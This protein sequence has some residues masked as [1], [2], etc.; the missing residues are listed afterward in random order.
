MS[1]PE[2]LVNVIQPK[3]ESV[4]LKIGQQNLPKLEKETEKRER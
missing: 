1:F 4:N 2:Q 3:I